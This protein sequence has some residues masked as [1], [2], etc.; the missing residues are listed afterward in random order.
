MG[1]NDRFGNKNKK[2][3]SIETGKEFGSLADASRHFGM[4]ISSIHRQINGDVANVFKLKYSNSDFYNERS[5]NNKK[6]GFSVLCTETGKTWD[7]VGDAASDIG[8]HKSTL[9]QW[10]IG[11]YENKTSLIFA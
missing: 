10:L 4:S 3:I 6:K 8:L 7:S 2:V 11:M 1:R 9:Y 5:N